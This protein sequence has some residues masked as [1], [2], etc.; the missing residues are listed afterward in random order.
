MCYNTGVGE[1]MIKKHKGLN[2]FITLSVLFGVPM[3]IVGAMAIDNA[4]E[5]CNLASEKEKYKDVLPYLLTTQNGM[6]L[7]AKVDK[8]ITVGI[9]MSE[10]EREQAVKAINDIQDISNTINYKILDTGET[11]VY[12]DI[13]LSIE[14][15]MAEQSHAFGRANLTYDT[16]TGYINYPIT[17][18]ID[19]SIINYKST[20]GVNLV[21]YVVKHEMMHTLGF[22]DMKDEQY[23]NKTVMWYAVQDGM[24][25]DDFSTLDKN[26]I[27]SMYDNK[28][29]T[30]Q[31][32][33]NI[34]FVCKV[35]QKEDEYSM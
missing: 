35:K 1:N 20:Q 2:I 13:N 23:Y 6:P 28:T 21:N 32:P 30:V 27:K 12:A 9:N 14:P 17:I 26:N 5:R 10:A 4:V 33:N 19:D 31:R 34:S 29:I 11:G 25:L 15:N 16:K 7:K 8:P 3:T 22:R 18:T 24:E